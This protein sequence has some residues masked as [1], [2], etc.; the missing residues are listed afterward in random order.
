MDGKLRLSGLEDVMIVDAGVVP[1]TKIA[2]AMLTVLA[3]G[4]MLTD[5][6]AQEAG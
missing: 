2:N 1:G 4:E 5:M 3:I 6:D